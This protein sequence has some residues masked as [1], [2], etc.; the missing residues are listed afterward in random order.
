MN[1]LAQRLFAS[2][3]APSTLQSYSAAFRS[4]QLFCFHAS[5]QSLPVLEHNLILFCTHLS[6]HVAAKTI[7]SYLS[8]IRFHT[9]AIGSSLDVSS[10]P[11][12]Y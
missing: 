2:S 3:L 11:R 5:L 9:I 12:L 8:G 6:N 4:Y 7:K 10:M 1:S